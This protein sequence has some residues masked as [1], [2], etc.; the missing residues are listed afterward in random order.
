[1]FSV[2]HLDLSAHQI[3]YNLL[4]LRYNTRL[5]VKTYTDELTPLDSACEVYAGANWYE[6][7]VRLCCHLSLLNL[8]GGGGEEGHCMF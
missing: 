7:E 4:S 6:R 2:I 8:G 1:M 3:V 5:R